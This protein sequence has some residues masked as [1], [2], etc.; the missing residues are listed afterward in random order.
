VP[1]IIV[2]TSPLVALFNRGDRYFDRC[3]RFFETARGPFVTNIAVI[4]E[5]THLLKFSPAGVRDCLDWLQQSFE[6][7]NATPADLPRILEVMSKYADLPADFADASLVALCERT[8][9]ELI[10]TLDSDFDVYRLANG[11]PLINVLS[12]I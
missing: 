9:I 2:D 12:G 10:A 4:T 6:I 7:D 5:A 11:K 8:G 1:N 3:S